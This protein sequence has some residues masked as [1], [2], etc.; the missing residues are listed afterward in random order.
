MVDNLKDVLKHS[1]IDYD[2]NDFNFWL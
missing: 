1:L 2:H